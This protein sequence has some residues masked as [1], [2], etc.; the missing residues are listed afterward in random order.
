MKLKPIE[1]CLIVAMVWGL[2][3]VVMA[4]QGGDM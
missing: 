2:V 4:Q 1:R 3:L